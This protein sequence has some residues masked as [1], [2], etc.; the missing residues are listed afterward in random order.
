[1]GTVTSPVRE[2]LFV[3]L[4]F[5]MGYGNRWIVRDYRRTIP[6]RY[7]TPRTKHIILG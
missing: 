6:V 2:A 5:V 7:K 1:M 4:A 3:K